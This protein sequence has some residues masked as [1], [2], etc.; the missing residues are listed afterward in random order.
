MG[1]ACPHCQEPLPDTSDAFC[2]RCRAEITPC[3]PASRAIEPLAAVAP[4]AGAIEFSLRTGWRFNGKQINR[5]M[6]RVRRPVEWLIYAA[7][8]A[9]VAALLLGYSEWYVVLAEVA[10]VA[11][12]AVCWGWRT[13]ELMR[14]NGLGDADATVRADHE[15]ISLRRGHCTIVFGWPALREVWRYPD[16]VFLVFEP[17]EGD[18]P[19]ALWP[20]P[21]EGMPAEFQSLLEWQARGRGVV[22]A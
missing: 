4:P 7:A 10:A 2:P 12:A 11:L 3:A 9:S 14:Y 16:A 22:L 15:R 8:L 13:L 19:G 1:I 6:S 20:L 21:T 17:S 5:H 18:G